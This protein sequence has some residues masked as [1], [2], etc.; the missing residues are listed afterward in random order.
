MYQ[1]P[2]PFCGTTAGF[3]SPTP[4]SAIGEGVKGVDGNHYSGHGARVRASAADLS[5]LVRLLSGDAAGVER[6]LEGQAECVNGLAEICIRAG[7]SVVLLRAIE[8]SPLRSALAPHC[9]EQ[10][11]EGQRR[12]QA[13]QQAL[14]KALIGLAERFGAAGQPFILLK[15]PYLASRFYGDVLGR[16]FVDIDLL[17][18]RA[19]RPHAFALIGEA[20]FRRRSGTLLGEGL[21]SFFVH[22]FDFR[23]GAVSVDL[24][25]DLSRHLSLR[26][27]E[28][29]LWAQRASFVIAGRSYDVLSD[30]HE[31]IF[32]TLSL[33]RDIERGRPKP[34]NVIDI[35]QI[36]TATDA[37]IDWD[38]LLGAGDGTAG[39]LVNVLGLCLEVVDAH[40][41]A[42]HL[43]AALDRHVGGRVLTL[44]RSAGSPMLF[45]P[46]PFGLGNKLWAARAYDTSLPAWLLWWAASLP[47]RLAVHRQ[48]P[49]QARQR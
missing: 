9:L 22:A 36:V 20:G 23:S 37:W 28:G 16:E 48:P 14:G 25:W 45:R 12:Q 3:G 31:V 11:Q 42:P 2:E 27:D 35:I 30:E 32:A 43:A 38:A 41:L 5:L 1:Q 29:R 18:P 19:D 40:D 6:C 4:G 49:R 8:G 13:R 24:H 44:T 47:F 26:L 10:L 17:I 15:G 21:T 7:L 39:P 33:L 34:K 46:T